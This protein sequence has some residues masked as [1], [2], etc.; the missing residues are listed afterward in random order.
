M[1]LRKI[2]APALGALLIAG[3]AG[4]VWVSAGRN[5]QEERQRE[6]ASSVTELKCMV[7]SEKLAM[8]QD[9]KF[10]AVLEKHAMRVKAEK[11]GSRDIASRDISGYDCGFP[12]GSPA[13]IALQAKAKTKQSFPTF[14]TPM[15]I[16]SWASL[17]PTL[18][19]EGILRESGG[20][21]VIDMK[22]LLGLMN[23]EARWSDLKNNDAY[24]TGKSVLINSTNLRTSNSASMYLALASYVANGGNVVESMGRADQIAP[25]LAALF[26]R[27]GLQEDSS[28][29]PFEDYTTMGIGKAP[30][31]M[32]YES[33]FLEYQ[34]RRSAPNP[35]MRLFY[36][37]PTIYTKHILVPFNDKGARFGALLAR[38]PELQQI[39]AN[40]GYRASDPALFG[41][42]L[43]AHKLSAPATLVDVVDPPS[44]DIL[45]RMIQTIEN[46]MKQ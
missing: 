19:A 29:G 15:A 45:E 35:D 41:A 21:Q 37:Q 23:R 27:Q 44:Y 36:P 42:F 1:N 12:S 32:V 30:L 3:V 40:Y 43:K 26:L 39:A 11:V 16:A 4:A 18:K 24:P 31:V 22:A 14:F 2:A 20:A 9:P 10:I 34:A 5:A 46:K 25:E 7:G 8:F 28:A 33:Q 38:D 13:A 6:A 17:A